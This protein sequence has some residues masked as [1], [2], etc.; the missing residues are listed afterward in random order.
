MKKIFLVLV[1]I[2]TTYQLLIGNGFFEIKS[3]KFHKE[4]NPF[5]VIVP[6]LIED[7]NGKKSWEKQSFIELK[8]TVKKRTRFDS[9]FAKVYFYDENKNLITYISAPDVATRPEKGRYSLP[10]FFESEKSES[11]FFLIPDKIKNYKNW[12][13]LAIFGDYNETALKLLK[14]DSI[15][16]YNYLEKTYIRRNSK[17]GRVDDS[18]PIIER[19]LKTCI[20]IQPKLT[21]L[22]LPSLNGRQP[23]GIFAV[24]LIANSVEDIKKNILSP[25]YQSELYFIIEFAKKHDLA[26]LCWGARRL[27]DPSRNWDEYTKEDYKKYDDNFDAIAS[28]WRRGVDK[29]CEEYKLSNNNL[30][31]WGTS[32]AAQ[33]AMRIALRNS[34]YFK[35]VCL[36]IPSSFDRPSIDGKNILWCITT[37]ERENGY[38][39]SIKFF[40]DCKAM[41]YPIIYKA[42][43]GLGHQ[44]HKGARDFA[45]FFCENVHNSNL[46]KE[47]FFNPKFYGDLMHQVYYRSINSN[48]V[49]K[50]F[51]VS[52]PFKEL[53]EKWEKM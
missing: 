32:I 30:L 44:G 52:L 13:A 41:G 24:C 19:T 10:A 36:H 46:K 14:E 45:L 53:A 3:I 6:K 35:S 2:S 48:K 21:L 28:T 34:N 9:I 47:D 26:L 20:D 25:P 39:R 16:K 4:E 27:W 17:K 1:L 29:L 23:K 11:L 37:G 22:F 38:D 33:Y 8:V 42:I 7:E 18:N 43:P 50:Y 12:N 15:D 49:P 5:G 51:K 31:L 40:N